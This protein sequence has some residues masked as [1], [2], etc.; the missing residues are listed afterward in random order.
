M[1]SDLSHC[2]GENNVRINVCE[3]GE[4]HVNKI[5]V[6]TKINFPLNVIGGNKD[7]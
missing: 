4:K 1:L 5:Q 3:D 2:C 7:L 6:V